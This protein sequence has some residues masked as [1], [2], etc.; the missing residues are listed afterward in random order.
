MGEQPQGNGNQPAR[1]D[2]S[3]LRAEDAQEC[4]VSAERVRERFHAS[5][6]RRFRGYS[7]RFL[8]S[9]AQADKIDFLANDSDSLDANDMELTGS[10]EAES[11]FE[12]KQALL[13]FPRRPRGPPLLLGDP[14]E[15][16][17]S[18]VRVQR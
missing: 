9:L 18:A 14:D 1:N 7:F 2:A 5:E 15:G 8:G 17:M 16:K 12:E 11:A 3:H 13:S 10:V 6:G 4:T